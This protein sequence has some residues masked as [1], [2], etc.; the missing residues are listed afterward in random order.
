MEENQLFREFTLVLFK[1]CDRIENGD[2]CESEHNT[3]ET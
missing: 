3:N 1:D 2:T